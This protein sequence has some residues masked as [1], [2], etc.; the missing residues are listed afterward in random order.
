[1]E[2]NL[3]PVGKSLLLI[4]VVILFLLESKGNCLNESS[5]LKYFSF[6]TLIGDL[7]LYTK[8]IKALSVLFFVSHISI[9]PFILGLSSLLIE[10]STFNEIATLSTSQNES[11]L[12]KVL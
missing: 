2:N 1:M 3:Y 4:K 5:L 8:S 7:N 10:Q 12:N 9:S 11:F 6:S